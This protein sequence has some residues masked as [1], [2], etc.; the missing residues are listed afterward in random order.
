[1]VLKC[2]QKRDQY[3]SRIC[4]DLSEILLQYLS[5]QDKAR[6]QCV[7]RQF[8]R[9]IFR[10]HQILFIDDHLITALL[11]LRS[12][13]EIRSGKLDLNPLAKLLSKRVVMKKKINETYYIEDN[14]QLIRKIESEN[15]FWVEKIRL[16][17]DLNEVY[18]VYA[19]LRPFVDTLNKPLQ[20]LKGLPNRVLNTFYTLINKDF[21]RLKHVDLVSRE[22]TKL[23]LYDLKYKHVKT[24]QSV[25]TLKYTG[26]MEWEIIKNNPNIKTIQFADHFSMYR[27]KPE[28]QGS[29]FRYKNLNSVFY[30]F[31]C[32][33]CPYD[34][35]ARN[36]ME[37]IFSRN[38]NIEKITLGNRVDVNESLR[39]TKQFQ[40]QKNLTTFQASLNFGKFVNVDF[41][42]LRFLREYIKNVKFLKLTLHMNNSYRKTNDYIFQ[43]MKHDYALKFFSVKQVEI[44]LLTGSDNKP[45]Y[46]SFSSDMIGC[47]HQLRH[48]TIDS[49]CDFYLDGHFFI[50]M[51]SN[52]YFLTYLKITNMSVS[53]EIIKEL[54]KLINL[55]YLEIGIYCD[56]TKFQGKTDDIVSALRFN[57]SKLKTL[58]MY[59]RYSERKRI[60]IF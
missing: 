13:N 36:V 21:R 17:D 12:E 1:M 42:H 46:P 41:M 3:N 58:A 47:S 18:F 60:E 11:A 55:K 25:R 8:Q 45:Q 34:D 44:K 6:L 35:T 26:L 32:V 5:L 7:C 59:H 37:L 52:F 31:H 4:D 53:E 51:S 2:G 33:T 16:F 56:A 50:D 28:F 49:F 27:I 19:K 43:K 24:L 22:L 54:K 40:N 23:Q 29:D 14:E 9:T 20:H 39:F 48:L 57:S 38:E 15:E 10:K 30:C